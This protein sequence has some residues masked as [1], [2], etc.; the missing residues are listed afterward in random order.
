MGTPGRNQRESQSRQQADACKGNAQRMA[1]YSYQAS[2]GTVPGRSLVQPSPR[3]RPFRLPLLS[4]VASN[5]PS[6]GGRRLALRDVFPIWRI[7]NA[8]RASPNETA[9]MGVPQS[10]AVEWSAV[11]ERVRVPRPRVK[12]RK[13]TWRGLASSILP[14]LY[15]ALP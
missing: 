8:V 11:Q 6:F 14:S 7:D 12:N 2:R 9:C 3:R 15:T 4:E 13:S 5:S 10:F 1:Q